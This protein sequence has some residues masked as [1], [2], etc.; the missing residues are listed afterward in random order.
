MRFPPVCGG[1]VACGVTR[2]PPKWIGHRFAVPPE[3]LT[4]IEVFKVG[5]EAEKA[6][7]VVGKTSD[8]RWA[9]LKTRVV[10]T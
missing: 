5:D 2:G 9:G 8:G 7:F 3:Q 1:S 10:E 4:G 6:V